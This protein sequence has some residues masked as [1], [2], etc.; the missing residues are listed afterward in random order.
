[1]T[2]RHV[3]SVVLYLTVLIQNPAVWDDRL[4]S[5]WWWHSLNHTLSV[6]ARKTLEYVL[7]LQNAPCSQCTSG[8][9]R[10]KMMA[11]DAIHMLDTPQHDINGIP[12]YTSRRCYIASFYTSHGCMLRVIQAQA[13]Y[14]NICSSGVSH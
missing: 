8:P 4:P 7:Y 3:K 11:Q 2:C 12:L 9:N 10:R 13:G 5:R 1:M 6:F 14:L